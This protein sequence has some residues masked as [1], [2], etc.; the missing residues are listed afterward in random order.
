MLRLAKIIGCLAL[1]AFG[2]QLASGYALLG[3]GANDPDTWQIP[4]IGYMLSGDI[5]TPK[6]LGEEYR[7]NTPVI[8]YGFDQS[9]QDYFGSNGVAAVEQAFAILN[10]LTNFSKYSAAL[11]EAPLETVRA[12]YRAQALHLYDLKTIAL[13]L[14]VEELG[15]AEP[16]RY[17]WTLRSRQTQPGLSCPWMTYGVIKRNFDPVTWEPSSY[18]NG[19]LYSYVI[20]EICSGGPPLANT[21]PFTV[22]PLVFNTYPV[23]SMN[24][25]GYGL[26]TT[27]MTRDDIGGLRYI[28]GTNNVNWESM[29]SDSTF[30]S[31]N[32]GGGQQ[33]LIT[34]NLT[35]LADQ[36]LTNNAAALQGLYPD[37]NIVSTVNIFTNIWV[38]NTTA[39]FT[40]YPM[41][42]VGTPP[43]LAFTT[44]RTL[45]VQT[46]YHHTFGNLM[47]FAF[48]NG[49]WVMVPVPDVNLL[50]GR[51]FYTVQTTTVIN[52]PIDPVGTSPHV[53][54]TS[55]TRS[56]NEVVG[57]FYILPPSLCSIAIIGLQATF[58]NSYTNVVSSS[59][60]A[61]LGST[62]IQSY[63]QAIVNYSTNHAFT[64][65]PVECLA[66]NVNLRQGIDHLTFVRANYDSL[67][68]RFF[69]PITNIYSQVLISNSQPFTAWMRRV[70]TKPDFLF[71]AA[72][73][74]GLVAARTSTVGN[75]NDAN[76]NPG[77]AGPGNIEP[78]MV[79]TF[80]KVG[81]LL[82]NSYSTNFIL[83]GLSES[84]AR[85]N[86]I[87]GSFDGS[88]NAPVVYPSG[89]SIANLE[90][91][92]LFQ[93]TTA[94][95]PNGTAH[96]AYPATQLQSSGAQSLTWSLAG[97]SLPP[98]LSLSPSGVISG[99]PAAG[100]TYSFTVS[101]TG[102]IPGGYSRTI[103]RPL[104]ITINP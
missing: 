80:N 85:T 93:I 88:T 96:T 9:F 14:V 51:D 33:L 78:N 102:I 87:W 71:T 64:Y 92:I 99:T 69:Q 46:Q 59:T 54:T 65:Y 44:T 37:L 63:S 3:P 39:Y 97:G 23:T 89:T 8:Y 66:T 56:T 57:E 34:S 36:A 73:L 76:K 12:N 52:S 100:G 90:A 75:Y 81:P 2:G 47:T 95:P 49:V 104:S 10:G 68:G 15:L 55:V 1:L 38:T 30:F 19:T 91:Q 6:N 7:W 84:T 43:H 77:T 72:D 28:Y 29:S 22:D 18:L 62:N 25:I 70:V 13:N 79:I 21:T 41:D 4:E 35:L 40:N 27:S 86:F 74:L 94:R 101:L 16:D 26:Y 24:T 58:T 60:N 42:P 50:T 67:V 82:I 17:V 11:S 32:T 5:G 53:S 103:T 48:R 61:P 20:D 83:G 98:G 31:T 45:T